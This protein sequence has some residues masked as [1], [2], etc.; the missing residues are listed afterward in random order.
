MRSDAAFRSAADIARRFLAGLASDLSSAAPAVVF[1][2]DERRERDAGA[3]APRSRS[4]SV[5]ALISACR[6]ISAWRSAIA[7][8]MGLMP[9]EGSGPTTTMSIAESDWN[10]RSPRR[11][12]VFVM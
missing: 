7:C 5:K 3:D 2:V 11:V 1:A 9:M 6:S 12:L 4:T 8:P 10:R